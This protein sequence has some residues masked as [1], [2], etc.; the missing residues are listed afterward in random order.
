MCV[1]VCASVS[2]FV[3]LPGVRGLCVYMSVSGGCPNQ[4][5]KQLFRRVREGTVSGARSEGRSGGRPG[6]RPEGRSGARSGGRSGGRP[7]G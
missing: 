7:E 5:P 4:D 2:S 3:C 6:G 1:R